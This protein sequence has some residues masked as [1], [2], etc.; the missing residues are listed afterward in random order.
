[1]QGPVPCLGRSAR[2]DSRTSAD[3]WHSG[4]LSPDFSPRSSLSASA[5]GCKGEREY[6]INGVEIS[7]NNL[8]V[9]ETTSVGTRP[10]ELEHRGW[11]GSSH[12]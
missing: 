7:P 12:R 2:A 3:P 5:T 9:P 10:S 1:M 6:W 11:L 8:R 4:R